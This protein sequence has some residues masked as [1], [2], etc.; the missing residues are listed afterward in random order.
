LAA[1]NLFI[2]L[3]SMKLVRSLP[4]CARG[5]CVELLKSFI[6][7]HLDSVT[8]NA[9]PQISALE[10]LIAAER[11]RIIEA[12]F[13]SFHDVSPTTTDLAA[14]GDLETNFFTLMNLVRENIHDC[15][16]VEH[17]FNIRCDCLICSS[18]FLAYRKGYC[19]EKALL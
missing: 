12:Q 16:E 18:E 19:C 15:L 1:V 10:K 13:V 5:S 4:K 9:L 7:Q 8:T 3:H 11:Q 6:K 2:A 14:G 17:G